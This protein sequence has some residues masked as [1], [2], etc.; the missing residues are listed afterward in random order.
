MLGT[1]LAPR[2]GM[3]ALFI[4]STGIF[5]LAQVV[6]RLLGCTGKVS[7]ENG[8]W[9]LGSQVAFTVPLNFLL[10]GAATL[11]RENWFFPAAMVVVG[12]HY[13]AFYH[14]VR[15]EAIRHAGRTADYRWRWPGLVRNI[16]GQAVLRGCFTAA[17]TVGGLAGAP[18]GRCI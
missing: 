7:P 10:V 15:H 11:Y 9:A 12:A 1:W 16:E 3:A 5:P 14:P 2:A 4:G 18:V 13:L 6:I 8:L 17:A